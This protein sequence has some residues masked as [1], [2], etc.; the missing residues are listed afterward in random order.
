[1]ALAEGRGNV[2]VFLFE[3]EGD[4]LRLLFYEHQPCKQHEFAGQIVFDA[5]LKHTGVAK[6]LFFGNHANTFEVGLTDVRGKVGEGLQGLLTSIDHVAKVKQG[7]QARVVGLAE[8]LRDFVAFELLVLLEI[9]MQV[10]GIG[11]LAQVQQVAADA[12]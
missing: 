3:D 4:H 2:V 9:E 1:V 8:Q 6:P 12:V 10:M 5:T 11:L 7:M